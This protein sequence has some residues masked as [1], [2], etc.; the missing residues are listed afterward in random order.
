MSHLFFGGESYKNTTALALYCQTANSGVEGIMT[1]STSQ[2]IENNI[3]KYSQLW[4]EGPTALYSPLDIEYQKEYHHG[5][6]EDLSAVLDDVA[7]VAAVER[8]GTISGF[9]RPVVS[10]GNVQSKSLVPIFAN[11]CARGNIQYLDFLEP[12][13]SAASRYLLERGSFLL[14]AR[15]YF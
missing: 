11:L 8:N 10:I 3:E 9:G 6:L 12:G 14:L 2:S 7:V 13:L 15:S 1:A 4:R 5:F